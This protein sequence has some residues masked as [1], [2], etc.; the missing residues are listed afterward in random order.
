MRVKN[1]LSI[2][3]LEMLN[4]FQ[5]ILKDE[6]GFNV[7]KGYCLQ[8]AVKSIEISDVPN[9]NW[10]KVYS[11]GIK[12]VLENKS[13]EVEASVIMTLNISQDVAEKISDIKLLLRKEYGCTVYQ[14]FT[15]SQIITFALLKKSGKEK[16][17]YK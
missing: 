11:Q 17:Y 8:E 6:F 16:E 5:T 10:K 15:I 2:Q 14:N 3:T 12:E 4:L 7:T 1:R 9:I 13:G